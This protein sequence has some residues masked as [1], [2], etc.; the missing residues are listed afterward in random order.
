MPGVR[1]E[2]K[3]HLVTG[4]KGLKR[5]PMARLPT[6]VYALFGKVGVQDAD[7][8]AAAPIVV[9]VVVHVFVRRERLK[10][11]ETERA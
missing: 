9:W 7:L 10:M 2:A 11:A 4:G 5:R 8:V 3:V 6:C 1:L